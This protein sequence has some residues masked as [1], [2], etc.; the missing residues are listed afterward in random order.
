[1]SGLI[2]YSFFFYTAFYIITFFLGAIFYIVNYL[3][4]CRGDLGGP[5]GAIAIGGTG[6][7]ISKERRRTSVEGS[8]RPG[9]VI[10][11]VLYV[12][13]AILHIALA[14][15]GK[16]RLYTLPAAWVEHYN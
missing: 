8:K 6:E 7:E 16:A 9:R 13:L 5:I 11:H 10:P 3:Y 14:A 2:A 4:T 15:Q 12:S 1:M